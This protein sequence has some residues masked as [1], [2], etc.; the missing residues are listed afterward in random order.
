MCHL[1]AHALQFSGGQPT[2][3]LPF[4]V[5]QLLP[6]LGAVSEMGM[7]GVCVSS[8]VPFVGLANHVACFSSCFCRLMP[9][10]S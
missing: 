6:S 5:A 7:M 9:A 4:I 1:S 8:E 2:Y 10:V 3:Q